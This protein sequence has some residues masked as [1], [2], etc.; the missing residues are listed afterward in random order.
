MQVRAF[1]CGSPRSSCSTRNT[2]EKEGGTAAA[3]P[4]A[5]LPSGKESRRVSVSLSAPL[6]GLARS[7]LAYIANIE[8][9]KTNKNQCPLAA[10]T[11]C[12]KCTVYR[13]SAMDF[14]MGKRGKRSCPF[15][16]SRLVPR[17]APNEVCF[18]LHSCQRRQ[19]GPATL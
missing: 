19:A 17:T 2:G 15:W 12:V 5:R 8:R 6:L 7:T 11:S 4:R 16:Q 9:D 3:L 10:V 18:F 1:T 13:L 14:L